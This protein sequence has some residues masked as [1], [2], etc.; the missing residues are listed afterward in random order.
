VK[1]VK[2]SNSADKVLCLKL[3]TSRSKGVTAGFKEETA[4]LKGKTGGF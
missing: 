4:P 3:N 2:I 1:E